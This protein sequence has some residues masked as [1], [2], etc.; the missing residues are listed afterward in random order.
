MFSNFNSNFPLVVSFETLHETEAM[1]SHFKIRKLKL[2]KVKCLGY[3]YA[4]IRCHSW[5]QNPVLMSSPN[6]SRLHNGDVIPSENKFRLPNCSA[7]G[8]A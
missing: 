4:A 2:R 6:H 7:W 3:H 1:I 8:H 5:K